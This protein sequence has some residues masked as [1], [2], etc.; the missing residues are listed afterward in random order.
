MTI[1]LLGSILQFIMPAQI[2]EA[3]SGSGEGQ[4]TPLSQEALKETGDTLIEIVYDTYNLGSTPVD[5]RVV[6][7]PFSSLDLHVN[8][9]AERRLELHWMGEGGEPRRGKFE[10]RYRRGKQ[11]ERYLVGEFTLECDRPLPLD[12]TKPRLKN[13]VEARSAF[14]RALI[15][16]VNRFTKGVPKVS[17]QSQG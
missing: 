11:E 5:F 6:Y 15:D 12:Q 4:Q 14:S 16:F 1:Q 10:S 9:P 7:G 17:G 8:S 2:T 3:R 13:S